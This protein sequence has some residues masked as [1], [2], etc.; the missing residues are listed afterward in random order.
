MSITNLFN[1]LRG[2]QA[3]SIGGNHIGY[4]QDGFAPQAFD[5]LATQAR[6]G[7]ML[8]GVRYQKYGNNSAPI[9]ASVN[10]GNTVEGNF[11]SLGRFQ[12]DDISINPGYGTFGYWLE[13][14]YLKSNSGHL[15]SD[16]SRAAIGIFVS[17]FGYEAQEALAIDVWQT[18]YNGVDSVESLSGIK[19]DPNDVALN[20]GISVDQS[21]ATCFARGYTDVTLSAGS[22]TT[23]RALLDFSTTQT[24][25]IY[26]SGSGV[27]LSSY[28]LNI[29]SNAGG[30]TSAVGVALTP[31]LYATP[32]N[33][34]PL[35]T[36]G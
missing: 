6:G 35:Y 3:Q 11:T 2:F 10:R 14:F 4:W 5:P 31:T 16:L 13:I 34:I 29:A 9:S 12:V 32:S 27:P 26:D 23:E 28:T 33:T 24:M 7:I 22:G 20:V 30:P 21:F 17:T 19:L 25:G 15:S 36:L 18:I 1:K 8:V